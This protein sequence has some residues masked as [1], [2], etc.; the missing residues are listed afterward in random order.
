MIF[1][2]NTL[3]KLYRYG[4]ALCNNEADAYDLLQDAL[5]RFLEKKA[6][7]IKSTEAI[8][9]LRRMMRNQ[10]IDQLRRAKKFPLEALDTIEPQQGEQEQI[11]MES[12]VISQQLLQ[13]IWGELLPL[14]RELVYLWAFE[15]FNARE[16]AEQLDVPRG[17]ILSRIHRL[18]KKIDLL[19][20]VIDPKNE[21]GYSI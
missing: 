13:L 19:L 11:A 7:E 3:N 20:T 21:R 17:T 12:I 2:H 1:D 6:K 14:E 10:F 4:Y 18:R 9:Y 15:G 16:I 5:T 8:P